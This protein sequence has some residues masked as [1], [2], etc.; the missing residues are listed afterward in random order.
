MTDIIVPVLCELL[1][2]LVGVAVSAC[3][4]L[5]WAI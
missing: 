3:F 5:W 1:L 4:I 2:V